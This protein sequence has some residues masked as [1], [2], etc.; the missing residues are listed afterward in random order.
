MKRLGTFRKNRMAA[1]CSGIL[2]RRTGGADKGIL[3]AAAA[4]SSAL[5]LPDTARAQDQIEEVLVTGSRIVRSGMQT[6]TP[7]TAVSRQEL[8]DLDPGNLVDALSQ[9]P[10]FLNN[11][12]ATDRGNF[13]G[14]AGGAYLNV[15]GLGTDRTLTLLNGRRV[16]P[17]DRNSSVDTNLFP[18][19]LVSR[20]EVVTGG[21]SAAY[22]ADAL[23]GVV[24]FILD[25]RYEGLEAKIQGGETRYDDGDNWEASVTGGYELGDRMHLTFSVEGFSQ[26]QV[27]GQIAA[28]DERTWFNHWGYV[29]NP[30]WYPGAPAGLPQR[31]VLPNVHS[32]RH[33]PGGKINEPGFSFDQYTFI[34]DGTVLRPFVPGPIAT[35]WNSGTLSTSGGPEFEIANLAERPI[36]ST[37]VERANLFTNLDFEISASTTAF[38]RFMKGQNYSTRNDINGGLGPSMMGIWRGTIYRENAFLPEVV[39]QAME[40]EGLTDFRMDKNGAIV[41]RNNFQDHYNDVS[42][43]YQNIFSAG[44]DHELGNDWSLSGYIHYGKSQKEARLENLLRVDRW[45]LAQDAVEVYGDRR[46]LTDDDGTGGPDG[47]A[48]LVAPGDRGTGDIICNVQRYNPTEQEL[49][50]SVA[51]VLVS[52]PQG[53]V[54]IASP[55]GLDN[56]I[57]GCQPLNIFGWGNV[58]EAAQRYVVADKWAKSE[59][60][61]TFAEFVL[62]GDVFENWYTGSPLSF[63]LGLTYRDEKMSQ[64]EYPRETAVLGPPQNA[65]ELGIRGLPPGFT[66]GSPNLHQFSTLQTFGGSFDVY[67][68]FGETFIPLMESSSSA[69]RVSASLAVRRSEYSRAGTLDTWKVGLD[70]QITDSFRFRTT[71]SHDAREAT[72]SEQFDLNG[73][74]GTI[75]D[76]TPPAPYSPGDDFAI[77]VNSGGNPNLR[78]EEADTQVIGF[79]YQPQFAPGLSFSA[80]HYEIDLSETIGSLGTQRIVDDCY[81]GMVAQACSLVDRDPVTGIIT[82]VSN[83]LVNI[84]NA[85]VVGTDYELT[86][87]AEPDLFQRGGAEALGFRLL[88]GHL[89]DNSTTPLGGTRLDSAGATNLPKLTTT[90]TL[91]YRVGPWSAYL[92]HR[93]ID[94]TTLSASWVEGVDVDDL[95]VE[96]VSYANAGL[97][98]TH[99]TGN[100]SW[101]IFANV[102]NLTDEHPPAIA[103]NVG[104]SIPSSTGYS[105]HRP[106]ALGRR[107]VVGVQFDF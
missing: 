6:P 8:G 62:S 3:L 17:A 52:S 99:D 29:T 24:N 76:P 105:Q 98:Y 49:A 81:I 10:Q 47:L 39:R 64:V 69:R 40:D 44:F 22:G 67:E 77:T 57:A 26:D 25:T 48:D 74:G 20:V 87:N 73:G 12:T 86:F 93:Y 36:L 46:D 31:L 37:E 75:S 84:D 28:L 82:R 88:V 23:S 65:P 107:Y 42:E 18:E 41:G 61:Q 72:F 1:S 4:L 80:D 90:A 9:L 97:R 15:R 78:P 30:A 60:E 14:A 54:H 35:D 106:I 94:E 96:A 102:Q 79:V 104:R 70:A 51:D 5:A 16:P 63:S 7:V 66:G 53:L 59:V 19:A 89:K 92:Q 58:S 43:I 13:L 103:S 38:V 83:V 101:E 71:L 85:D 56:T 32:T 34:E 55:V 2:G 100:L 11:T 27:S 50:D 21:A 68:I 95:I 33:T 45:F 91:N